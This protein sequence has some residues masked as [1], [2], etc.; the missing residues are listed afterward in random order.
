MH[1][2]QMWDSKTRVQSRLQEH[3]TAVVADVFLHVEVRR[4]VNV[5]ESPGNGVAL[6]NQ[7]AE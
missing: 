7:S 3:L 5:L 1:T 6:G 4:L 2:S